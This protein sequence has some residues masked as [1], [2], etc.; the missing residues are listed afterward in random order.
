MED[1][2]VGGHR[3]WYGAEE[4]GQL[5]DQQARSSRASVVFAGALSVMALVLVISP[6]DLKLSKPG[7]KRVSPREDREAGRFV[8]SET[9]TLLSKTAASVRLQALLDVSSVTAAAQQELA[10]DVKTLKSM[11][12]NDGWGLYS[13]GERAS[14]DSDGPAGAIIAS[15]TAVY[16]KASKLAGNARQ[17]AHPPARSGE[18]L[19]AAE[20]VSSIASTAKPFAKDKGWSLAKEKSDMDKFYDSLDHNAAVKE[21]KARKQRAAK[22]AFRATVSKAKAELKEIEAT[23]ASNPVAPVMKPSKKAGVGATHSVVSAQPAAVHAAVVNSEEAVK[24]KA[25]HVATHARSSAPELAASF[26][27]VLLAGLETDMNSE[28][29]LRMYGSCITAI[30]LVLALSCCIQSSR[31][32]DL[33]Y[34]AL[35]AVPFAGLAGVHCRTFD[36]S[37][38]DA[39]TLLERLACKDHVLFRRSG[40]QSKDARGPG[41]PC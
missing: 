41:A 26:H 31:L 38:E 6:L 30:N 19:A 16:E 39:E 33:C 9:D 34:C 2:M 25:L 5:R 10:N 15:A 20:A 22:A 12:G 23:P 14:S 1:I 21:E 32:F 35:M 7:M 11:G 13:K 8:V 36:T 28:R 4:E 40:E 17:A 27:E 37:G 18:T 29:V 24:P 3:R